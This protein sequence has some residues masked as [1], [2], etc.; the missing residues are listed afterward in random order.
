MGRTVTKE[1]GPEANTLRAQGR[2]GW[3]R[4]TGRLSHESPGVAEFAAVVLVGGRSSPRP[5]RHRQVPP[6]FLPVPL[7]RPGTDLLPRRPARPGVRSSPSGEQA[8]ALAK[9]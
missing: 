6:D 4:S 5:V 8:A 7:L 9:L 1:K 3:T 2:R